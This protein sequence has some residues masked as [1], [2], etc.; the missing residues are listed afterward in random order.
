MAF[1]MASGD[2][3]T[4]TMHGVKL[5][6]IEDR[7]EKHSNIFSTI[8]MHNATR[9]THVQSMESGLTAVQGSIDTFNAR[10]DAKLKGQHTNTET[11][12]T[13]LRIDVTSIWASVGT[14]C[15][16]LI[17]PLKRLWHDSQAFRWPRFRRTRRLHAPCPLP[18][19]MSLPQRR[20]PWT[21]LVTRPT[22]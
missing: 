6:R 11:E 13:A 19:Q 9:E 21:R 2:H 4:V 15:R 22:T 3:I 16:V 8:E 20:C 18:R 17:P 5:N 7:L 12:M 10:L 14:S 1:R